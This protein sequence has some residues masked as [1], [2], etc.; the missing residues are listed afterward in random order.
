MP[1]VNGWPS[2]GQNVMYG[3]SGSGTGKKCTTNGKNRISKSG[4]LGSARSSS[5]SSYCSFNPGG[6]LS[7]ACASLSFCFWTRAAARSLAIWMGRK[8]TLL[9]AIWIESGR[10]LEIIGG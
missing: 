5:W 9:R 3:L 6:Y 4:T 7:P 10:P 2:V 1:R 8:D